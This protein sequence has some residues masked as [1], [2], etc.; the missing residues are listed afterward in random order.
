MNFKTTYI[1]FAGLAVIL[2]VLGV[3]LFMGPAT[4]NDSK[5]LLSSL[6]DKDQHLKDGEIDRVDRIEIKR[7]KP[8]PETLTF[9]KD[10]STKHWKVN[11]F[12]ADA[13]KVTS[14]IQQL[15][16]ADKTKADE[17]PK[18]LADWELNPP[19]TVV[20]ISRG[21]QPSLT[22]N[23]GKVSPGDDATAVI[24]ATSSDRPTDAIAVQKKKLD[25]PL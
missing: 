25:L 22:V 10:P 19:D 24:Y 16:N 8:D 2:A 18:N 4:T 13:L 5:F 23:L 7:T 9:V 12:R 11:G 3:T 15:F 20:T 14:L 6:Y 17:P 1:L 21:D